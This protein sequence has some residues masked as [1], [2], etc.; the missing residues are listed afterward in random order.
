MVVALRVDHRDGPV[1]ERDV[2]ARIDDRL[3]QMADGAPGADVA[4]IRPEEAALGR[5]SCGTAR[6][7]AFA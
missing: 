4:Q 3:A 2:G 7:P 6:R 1:V 5:R